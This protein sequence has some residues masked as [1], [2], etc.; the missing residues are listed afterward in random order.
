MVPF[1][2]W[3][4]AGGGELLDSPSPVSPFLKAFIE[5]R[6]FRLYSL[7]E[8]RFYYPLHLCAFMCL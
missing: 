2:R 6:I 7:L 4:E 1:G 5:K 3:K 8:E